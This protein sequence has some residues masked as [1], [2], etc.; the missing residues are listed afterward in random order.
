MHRGGALAA[1]AQEG[2]RAGEEF[3]D[4]EGL[5]YVIVRAQFE[6]E[7]DVGF[8]AFRSEHDDGHLQLFLAQETADLVA[9][10]LWKHEI[11]DDEVGLNAERVFQ[12]GVAIGG[13]FYA[14][15]LEFKIV[16][17]AAQHRAESSSMMRGI[18][19]V[20][21]GEH[22]GNASVILKHSERHG[23]AEMGTRPGLQIKG[24]VPGT[25]GGG[26]TSGVSQRRSFGIVSSFEASAISQV[27]S[28]PV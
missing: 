27:T 6:A 13:G 19:S 15:S 24:V 18:V 16:L 23:K 25:G 14:V 7:D 26:T 3:L 21:E 4:A 2:L 10:H 11:E 28:F 17:Q 1:A 8:L 20:R 5:G 22:G 12:A 9:V